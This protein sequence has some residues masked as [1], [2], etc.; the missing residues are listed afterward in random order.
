MLLLGSQ[1]L[2]A[3]HSLTPRARIAAAYAVGCEPKLMGLGPVHAIRA[4]A[5]ETGWGLAEVP[6]LEI[7]EAFAAQ[8][9]ACARELGLDEQRL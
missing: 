8:V 9:L 1:E 4:L 2:A 7:N 5:G 3:K 6:A